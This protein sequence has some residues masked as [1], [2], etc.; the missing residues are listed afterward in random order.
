MN[1]ILEWQYDQLVGA[2]LHLIRA[3]SDLLCKIAAGEFT[4]LAN[5]IKPGHPQGKEV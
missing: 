1:K 3:T 2:D 4:G 5:Q